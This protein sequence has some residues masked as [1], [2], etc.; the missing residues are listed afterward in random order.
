MTYPRWADSD[1]ARL[2]ERLRRYGFARNRDVDRF[3]REVTITDNEAVW[4]LDML[5]ELDG[6]NGGNQR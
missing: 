3:D 4:L 5:G 2:I 6:M 1:R